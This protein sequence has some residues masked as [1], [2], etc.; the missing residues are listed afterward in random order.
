M[1]RT[2]LRRTATSYAFLAP[3]LLLLGVFAFY[4]LL[5]GLWLSL[6]SQ[7]LF[8]EAQWVGLANFR[9]LLTQ[10][11]DFRLALA[12]SLK[13][14]MVVPVIAALSLALALLVEPALP[15]MGVFRA[16]FYIPVVTTMVVVALTWKFIFNEDNGLLN[17]L[18]LSTGLIDRP[19]HWLTS[20]GLVLYSIMAVTTW[21]G[22]GYYMVVFLAGLRSIPPQQIEAARIDGAR[23]WQ[24]LWHIKLPAL[25][26]TLQLVMVISSIAALQVFEE[27]YM[28][29]RGG[30]LHA[31]ATVVFMIWEA[32]FD[33]QAGSPN[34][35]YAA[36]MGVVL[37][38]LLLGFTATALWLS[39]RLEERG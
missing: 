10:D 31:S 8:G 27:V 18:L 16:L 11:L 3:A 25:R 23:A 35:G 2:E 37:F 36:A 28:M 15:G 4:P 34:M 26:P 7:P 6:Y 19:I 17:G 14:L 5:R 32:G 38:A 9:R 30:P 39:R 21:K 29:T 33:T 1:R 12:N 22:L 24:I 13:Y 20:Q